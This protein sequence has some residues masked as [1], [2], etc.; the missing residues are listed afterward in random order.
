MSCRGFYIF[1]NFQR[2]RHIKVVYIYIYIYTIDQCVLQL[3]M[4]YIR[5]RNAWHRYIH[6]PLISAYCS[7]WW[8]IQIT[9]LYGLLTF[10][11]IKC[12]IYIYNAHPKRYN[13]ITQKSCAWIANFETN[14]V[15]FICSYIDIKHHL[16]AVRV[17]II[18][19]FHPQS[20]ST[21][22]IRS[23]YAI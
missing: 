13:S 17:Q 15:Y 7:W 5:C 12:F 2:K 9:K 22:F 23:F 1:W 11:N 3:M 16:Q 21:V 20:L 6:I 19:N 14:F 18:R 4:T 10:S 8:F